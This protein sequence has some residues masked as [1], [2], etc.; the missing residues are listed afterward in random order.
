VD[1]VSR[2]SPRASE[3]GVSER[4]NDGVADVRLE[5]VLDLRTV[6]LP[7]GL[8]RTTVTIEAGDCLC[9]DRAAEC[10]EI[11]AVDEG[12]IDVVLASGESQRLHAGAFLFVAGLRDVVL[13]CAGTTPAVLTGIRRIPAA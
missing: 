2:A 13:C 6:G 11:L 5:G 4:G 3:R 1:E 8:V 12:A 10:G 7:P 9:A